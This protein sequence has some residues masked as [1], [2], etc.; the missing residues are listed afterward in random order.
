MNFAEAIGNLIIH[1]E[2]I[3]TSEKGHFS[4]TKNDVKIFNLKQFDFQL[5]ISDFNHDY[6][7]WEMITDNKDL[8]IIEL[9]D[10]IKVLRKKV[11]ELQLEISG[12]SYHKR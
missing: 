4:L 2:W 11:T 12:L 1:P 9:Q 10:E 7:E 5:P 3:M 6:V 8:S